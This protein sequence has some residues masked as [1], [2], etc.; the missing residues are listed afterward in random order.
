MIEFMG[1]VRADQVWDMLKGPDLFDD[2]IS[3]IQVCSKGGV[4]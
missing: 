2:R 3:R 4:Q 1:A